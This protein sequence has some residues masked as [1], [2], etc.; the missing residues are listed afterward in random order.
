[1]DQRSGLISRQTLA[2]ALDD[3]AWHHGVEWRE[4]VVGLALCMKVL[5]PSPL[6][7]RLTKGAKEI[8]ELERGDHRLSFHISPLNYGE[9]IWVV[10]HSKS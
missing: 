1:M 3:F 7:F 8:L 5:S 6:R 10:E 4:G 2:A 9:G